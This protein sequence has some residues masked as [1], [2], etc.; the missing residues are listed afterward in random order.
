MVEVPVDELSALNDVDDEVRVQL[1]TGCH[2]SM[3]LLALDV[4]VLSALPLKSVSAAAVNLAVCSGYTRR[5]SSR[6]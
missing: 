2:Q 1:T 4:L 3:H 6:C 5:C